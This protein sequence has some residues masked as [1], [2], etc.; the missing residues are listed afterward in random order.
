MG[1]VGQESNLQPAVVE[2]AARCPEASKNVQPLCSQLCSQCD[3]R[4]R[5]EETLHDFECSDL[6]CKTFRGAG[7]EN[8]PKRAIYC[9]SRP[10]RS[11]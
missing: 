5:V 6:V 4:L 3:W 8:A 11:A 1:Q 9:T 7:Q 2:H 10:S